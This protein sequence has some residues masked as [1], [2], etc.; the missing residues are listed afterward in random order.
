MQE[1]S[2]NAPGPPM[3]AARRIVP[4]VLTRVFDR[5]EDV[6]RGFISVFT[7][8]VGALIL[9]EIIVRNLGIQGLKWIDELGRIMLITTTLVG[10]SVAAKRHGHMIMDALYSVVS[11]KTA[12]LLRG[13]SYLIAGIFYLYLAWYSVEWTMRLLRLNRSMQTIGLPVYLVWI[14][15][16]FA[17]ATMGLRYVVAAI[18][19]FV[20]P[21]PL[22]D[23]QA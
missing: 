15:I 5:I 17:I 8:G 12:G 4:H 16:S 1:G 10:S 21:H 13:L 19:A 23:A 22:K 18:Q 7:L 9:Y 3:H 2:D 20:A 14:V 6:E 11:E